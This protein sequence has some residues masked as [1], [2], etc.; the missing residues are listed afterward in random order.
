MICEEKINQYTFD[1][2]GRR[3]WPLNLRVREA[4]GQDKVSS[5]RVYVQVTWEFNY[6][7]TYS[8]TSFI[9]YL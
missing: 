3:W 9:F 8:T 4:A 1:I 2:K 5:S 7:V 6:C